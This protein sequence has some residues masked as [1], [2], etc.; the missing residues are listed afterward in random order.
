MKMYGGLEV[1]GQLYSR[2]ALPPGERA[3]TASVVWGGG[4]RAVWAPEQVWTPWSREKCL[5]PA[6]N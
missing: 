4:G 2:A 1:S 6:W 5:I 3:T